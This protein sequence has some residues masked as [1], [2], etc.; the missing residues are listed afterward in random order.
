MTSQKQIADPTTDQDQALARSLRTA[1]RFVIGLMLLLAGVWVSSGVVSVPADRQAVVIGF[2]DAQVKAKQGGGLVWWWPSPI[3]EVRL[4]P[5]ASRKFS[6][7]VNDLQPG[8]VSFDPRVLG[9]VITGDHAALHVGAT[10]FWRVRDPISYAF[11]ADPQDTRRT[12]EIDSIPKIEQAIRRAF[13]RAVIHV[14][15]HA[16]INTIRVSGKDAIRRELIVNMNDMLNS[17]G[18]MPYAVTVENVEFNIALPRWASDAFSRAQRAQSE[19]D[20]LIAEAE[21]ARANTLAAAEEEAAQIIGSA[22]AVA[23]EML[24]QAFVRT[25]PIAALLAS[26][27]QDSAVVRYR[28]WRDA[29]DQLLLQANTVTLVPDHDALRVLLPTAGPVGSDAGAP[30]APQP[31]D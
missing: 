23:D 22:R 13:Q 2:G 18:S 31:Q 17:R 8:G 5:A 14:A 11:L 28:L 24:S 10:V 12:R 27:A 16:D 25:K 6:L 4:I 21:S 9:Y 7:E 30:A 26:P 1:M 15:A 19:A 3:G 20:Q 29:V